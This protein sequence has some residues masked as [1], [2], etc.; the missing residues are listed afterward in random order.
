M[1]N[2]MNIQHRLIYLNLRYDN[3]RRFHGLE[4]LPNCIIQETSGPKEDPVLQLRVSWLHMWHHYSQQAGKVLLNT[5]GL[6]L[7]AIVLDPDPF[8]Y[9]FASQRMSQS[10][11]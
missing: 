8:L 11:F 1:K 10:R 2:L 9:V 7:V 5:V 3:H 4:G 6:S